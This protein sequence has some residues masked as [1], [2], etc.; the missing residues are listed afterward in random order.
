MDPMNVLVVERDADWSQWNATS[1]LVGHA[2]LVLVQQADEPTAAFRMRVQE[3]LA[4]I[5]Q[6]LGSLV[7]LRGSRRSGLTVDEMV[8]G[9]AH[10]APKDVRTYSHYFAGGFAV[11]API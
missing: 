4:R 3:R 2:M 1:H 8:D 5:K 10:R 9:L 7:L 11:P 6:G